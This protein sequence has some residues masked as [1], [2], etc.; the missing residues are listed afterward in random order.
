MDES[1]RQKLLKTAERAKAMQPSI[2]IGL[3]KEF[4]A[5]DEKLETLSTESL[6]IK[7]VVESKLSEISENLKKKSEYEFVYE[8]DKESL[9]GEDGKDYVLTEQDKKDIAKSITVPVV[10]KIIEKTEIITE[11]GISYNYVV[12]GIA[13]Y[14]RQD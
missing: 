6:E 13:T 2:E 8:I 1:T 3:A 4:S 11:Q 12:N 10:E 5:L 14:V 7:D 9:K